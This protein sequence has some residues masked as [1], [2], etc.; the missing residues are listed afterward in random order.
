MKISATII[1]KD[2]E[3]NLPACLAS[4]DFVDEI[5]VLDS[6]SADRTAEICRAHPRVRYATRALDG[7]GSQKNAAADLAR[8]DWVLN[9]DADERVSPRLRASILAADTQRVDGFRVARENYF[10]GRRIR[11]CGWYPD[12]KLRLYDR[13]RCRFGERLVH[14]AVACAGPVGTLAGHLVHY[15]Y[16]DVSDYLARLERYSTLAAREVVRAG[17][18]PGVAAVA[19]RPLWMFVRTYLLKRG[20]LDGYDGLL[21]SILTAFSTFAKYAKARELCRGEASGRD[22][23]G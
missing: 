14:E 2:E 21:I 18:R 4:L 22:G 9:V 10:G 17:G 11:H 12:A 15:S 8:N 20:F 5:V 3:G 23:G 1:V 13:R 7:F 6:G 19:A 16:R